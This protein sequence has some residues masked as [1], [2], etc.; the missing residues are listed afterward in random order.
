VSA[1]VPT[2]TPDSGL[3][4]ARELNALD[5]N[6]ESPKCDGQRSGASLF[7]SL[8]LDLRNYGVLMCGESSSPVNRVFA[9]VEARH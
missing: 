8:C 4:R 5:K 2:N 9:L 7:T 3:V 1:V 6:E